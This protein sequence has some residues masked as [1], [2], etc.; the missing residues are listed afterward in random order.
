MFVLRKIDPKS[1]KIA[2]KK[3]VLNIQKKNKYIK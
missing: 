2:R 3:N 1:N